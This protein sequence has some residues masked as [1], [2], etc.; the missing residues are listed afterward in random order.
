ME[1][2]LYPFL[3]FIPFNNFEH[4]ARILRN[5]E[6]AYSMQ[7]AYYL[8]LRMNPIRLNRNV[9][10]V[11]LWTRSLTD[12]PL[13]LL[14]YSYISTLYE[15]H[16]KSPAFKRIFEHVDYLIDHLP[17]QFWENMDEDAKR[18]WPKITLNFMKGLLHE[19]DP[20]HYSLRRFQEYDPQVTVKDLLFPI[21]H[22]TYPTLPGERNEI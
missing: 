3:T 18:G 9:E 8:F 17:L 19:I 14:L 13:L 16:P 20:E 4:C 11:Y 1:Y 2:N 10:S 5:K 21:P 7:S 6:R 15:N 22:F 12:D